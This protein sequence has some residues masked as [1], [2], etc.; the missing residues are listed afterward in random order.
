MRLTISFVFFKHIKYF[1]IIETEHF[2][3]ILRFYLDTT[4]HIA[5]SC[6]KN[7][8]HLP[9]CAEDVEMEEEGLDVVPDVVEQEFNFLEFVNR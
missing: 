5:F 2:I 6:C 7:L 3:V 8:Q 1:Y 4:L 9:C